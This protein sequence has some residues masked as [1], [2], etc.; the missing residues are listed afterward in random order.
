MGIDLVKDPAIIEAAYN[1]PAG[2]T[3][4]FNKNLLRRINRELDAD[5]NLDEFEH[6]A[7]YLE[8]ESR[9]EMRLISKRDQEVWIEAIGRS[10]RFSRDEF[11]HTEWSHKYTVDSFAELCSRAGFAIETVWFD[12]KRWFASVLLK[13]TGEQS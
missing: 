7:P 13:P 5:F 1:D 4:E 2:V 10:F 11:I 3:A 12:S 8:H 9:V 6:D